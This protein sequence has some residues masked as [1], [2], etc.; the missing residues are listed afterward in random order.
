MFVELREFAPEPEKCLY[1]VG[2]VCQHL[3]INPKQLRVLLESTGTKF[4]QIIDG[5]AYLDFNGLNA[6]NDKANEVREHVDRA[7]AAAQ[8]N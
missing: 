2:A 3:Q 1:S 7:S 4:A 5:A 6:I 8:L